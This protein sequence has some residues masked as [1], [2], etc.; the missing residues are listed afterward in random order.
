MV[1]EHDTAFVFCQPSIQLLTPSRRGWYVRALEH[2][3]T[4]RFLF[5][6]GPKIILRVSLDLER[7]LSSQHSR[8]VLQICGH[9][10]APDLNPVDYNNLVSGDIQQRVHQSQL[11]SALKKRLLDVGLGLKKSVIDDASDECYKRL[12]G[13]V[14]AKGGHD[15][16][17]IIRML[18]RDSY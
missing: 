17:F 2:Q 9:L 12:R 10:I 14:Q 3:T 18:F 6:S 15:S 1:D 4:A 5:I 13:C 16:L 8:L 11:H 7:F